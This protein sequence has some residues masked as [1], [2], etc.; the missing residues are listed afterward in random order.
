MTFNK[1]HIGYALLAVLYL[2]IYYFIVR[3]ENLKLKNRI[4]ELNKQN[5][6]LVLNI[7]QT[8]SQIKSLDSVANILKFKVEQ[9]KNELTALKAKS[10]KIKNKYNEEHNR[11]NNLS[12]K[13]VVSEFTDAFEW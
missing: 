4:N 7:K 3:P 13:S 9:D 5:D 11:I 10:D 6:S 8:Q 1:H 2:V 12:S